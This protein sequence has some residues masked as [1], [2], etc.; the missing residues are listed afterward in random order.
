M[1]DSDWPWA[2]IVATFL[3]C[4]TIM[5]CC[6]PSDAHAAPPDT[7][8]WLAR[9]CAGE[10]G[11]RA[12]ETGECAA[13]WHV[14]RKRAK[15][16]GVTTHHKCLTY[17]AALKT[18]HQPWVMGLNRDGTRPRRW[19][20]R[21]IWAKHRAWWLAMLAAADAFVAGELADPRPGALHYGGAMDRGLDMRVWEALPRLLHRNT[22]YRLRGE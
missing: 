16:T 2:F 11:F 13:I 20:P 5:R 21:L 17:S 7:A 9:S 10:A 3:V 18:N 14:Y 6:A 1:S 15:L 22:F 12:T 4:L 8:L 19:P